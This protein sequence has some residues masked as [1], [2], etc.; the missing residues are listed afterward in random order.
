MQLRSKR[1]KTVDMLRRYS[2]YDLTTS[3]FPTTAND[4]G[5]SHGEL[6][7]ISSSF[8]HSHIGWTS[9]REMKTMKTR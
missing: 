5:M 6:R 8:H 1:D 3:V 4:L 9:A 2:L 7:H